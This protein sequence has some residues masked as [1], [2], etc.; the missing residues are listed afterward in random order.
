M[1]NLTF[2]I[3]ALLAPISASAHVPFECREQVS[4]VLENVRETFQVNNDLIENAREV[5]ET[6][7]GEVRDLAIEVNEFLSISTG[8]L[9]QEQLTLLSE[10]LECI[11]STNQTSP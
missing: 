7:A 2:S 1:K 4:A 5:S 11:E 6:P 10:L 8:L 9:A 3:L